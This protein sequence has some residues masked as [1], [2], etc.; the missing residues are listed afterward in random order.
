VS[1][2]RVRHAAFD[3]LAVQVDAHGDVL[4]WKL[5][6]QG[7]RMDGVRVPLV[8]Q[9]G[10][11]KP[12]V[13]ELPLSIRTSAGG[14]Y[15]DAFGPDGLLLYAYRG[16]DP[17]HRENRGLRE[18]MA[19]RL[20]L[21]YF[22]GVIPGQYLVSWPVFVVDDE[23][24]RLRFRV[25]LDAARV[26]EWTEDR[27]V[28]PYDLRSEQG[29]ERRRYITRELKVRLHQRSFRER[30]LRA[31]REQCALCR[32]RHQELL[33]AAHI[34]PD[35][36]TGGEPRVQNGLALCKLHHAA[37]DRQF[38]GIR[39]DYIVEVRP[40]ILDEE[41]GPM[42]LHGLK[43]L[44]GQAILLPRARELRPDPELLATRY[45]RYEAS[46]R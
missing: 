41:D 16:S 11:F 44:H 37:F 22:H 34:V 6:S 3:W 31:Y 30:V 28:T 15:D 25:A 13:M 18:L 17:E 9:Q 35:A 39:P 14:P 38:I 1:D 27:V 26:L 36:E 24:Q 7:F 8:S 46:A 32:L 4:P 21:V 12:A 29:D 43:G 45:E 42:L 2:A 40:E 19:R 20:P 33:D 5:L 10:I 23:P